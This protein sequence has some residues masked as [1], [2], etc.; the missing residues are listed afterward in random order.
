[1]RPAQRS[2]RAS[3]PSRIRRRS[4]SET[5][6]PAGVSRKT[7][8]VTVAE[9]AAEIDQAPRQVAVDALEVEDDRLAALEGVGHLL[10]V[11]EAGGVHDV[12]SADTRQGAYNTPSGIR[13]GARGGRDDADPAVTVALIGG[14]GGD[15]PHG[16][17][18]SVGAPAWRGGR[19]GA[20]RGRG[21]VHVDDVLVVDVVLPLVVERGIGVLGVVVG[22][23]PQPEP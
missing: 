3:P 14:R 21:G 5:W 19:T 15:G 13:V 1:M 17:G 23:L 12:G 8:S 22:V 7:W 20:R 9:A 10:D 4:S 6:A 11:V 2:S 16:A 18:P